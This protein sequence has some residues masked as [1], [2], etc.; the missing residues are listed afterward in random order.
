MNILSKFDQAEYEKIVERE[1]R[2]AAEKGRAEMKEDL[3]VKAS[4]AVSEGTLDASGVAD[5][6]GVSIEELEDILRKQQR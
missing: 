1:K 3:L 4:Y 5:L 6:F 2:E